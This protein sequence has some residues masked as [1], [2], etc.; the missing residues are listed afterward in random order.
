MRKTFLGLA[1]IAAIATPLAL[2]PS[3]SAEVV[4]TD[5]SCVPVKA[6]AAK[7][8]VEYKYVPAPGAKGSTQWDRTNVPSITVNK[9]TYL[10][11]ADKTRLIVD[12]PAVEAVTCSVTLPTAFEGE[13]TYRVVVPFT[14]GVDTFI[15]GARGYNQDTPITE[16]SVVTKADADQFWIGHKA[17]PGYVIANPAAGNNDRTLAQWHIDF[18]YATAGPD[19]IAL[20]GEN[21]SPIAKHI[22][23]PDEFL[24]EHSADG[25]LSYYSTKIRVAIINDTDVD[26]S[27]D[28]MYADQQDGNRVWIERGVFENWTNSTSIPAHSTKY[29]TFEVWYDVPVGSPTDVPDD[30]TLDFNVFAN[31]G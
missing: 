22:E 24:T 17:Q 16:D 27:V 18:T 12:V 11:D 30:L 5:P 3:A 9:V 14:K 31:N 6:A 8:H 2:A 4:S 7:T 26:K 20:G 29:V 25:S 19:Q 13:G 28:V 21:S 10:R 1:V 23:L 15:I